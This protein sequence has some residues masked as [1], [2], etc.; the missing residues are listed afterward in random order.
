MEKGLVAA[1]EQDCDGML[2]NA[3]APALVHEV[4][5][6][7]RCLAGKTHGSSGSPSCSDSLSTKA[8]RLDRRA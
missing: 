7:D 3:L 1:L 2:A 5:L 4:I 8:M 6:L